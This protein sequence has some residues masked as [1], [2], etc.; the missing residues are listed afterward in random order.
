MTTT[1][2]A[3]IHTLLVGCAT[4]DA[5]AGQI[6]L[7]DHVAQ[8]AGA[9]DAPQAWARL[10]E[11]ARQRSTEYRLSMEAAARYRETAGGGQ[12][13]WYGIIGDTLQPGAA[14]EMERCASHDHLGQWRR[15]VEDYCTAL[16]SGESA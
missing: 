11:A 14:D 8:R 2:S 3:A 10:L 12:A 16:W 7:G 6:A 1:D 15:G 5:P 9:G 4:G 13:Q